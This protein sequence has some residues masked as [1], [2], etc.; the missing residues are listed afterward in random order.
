MSD[1]FE[2]NSNVV[3]VVGIAA[4]S[5]GYP[6]KL[7]VQSFLNSLKL[8]V[9][10]LGY[11]C[12][13]HTYISRIGKMIQAHPNWAIIVFSQNPTCLSLKLNHTYTNA[14]AIVGNNTIEKTNIILA[15]QKY[16]ANILCFPTRDSYFDLNI[17]K[18]IKSFVVLE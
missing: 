18:I 5:T 15:R 6:M 3:N 8:N 9:F 1:A 2:F 12:E 10:D 4:D 17:Q 14:R 7:R 16:H 11:V 13:N